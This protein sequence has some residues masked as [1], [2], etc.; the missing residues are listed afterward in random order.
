MALAE[1]TLS[2]ACTAIAN[3]IVVAS[4]T[5][6][7]PGRLVQIGGEMMQVAQN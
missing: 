1:T 5:S 6:V 4:A 3:S 2:S 7:A